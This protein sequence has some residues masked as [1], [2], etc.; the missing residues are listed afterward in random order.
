MGVFYLFNVTYGCT[1][2]TYGP[3]YECIESR[4][5]QSCTRFVATVRPP[6]RRGR[7]DGSRLFSVAASGISVPPAGT[8]IETRCSVSRCED[9]FY[10][11][12]FRKTGRTSPFL[13]RSERLV[14]KRHCE[15]S[16]GGFAG[17]REKAWVNDHEVGATRS[18]WNIGLIAC[19]R[20]SWN[21]FMT[22]WYRTNDGSLEHGNPMRFGR[23]I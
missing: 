22:F 23:R 4:T 12:T 1:V 10:R 15:S 17:A 6:A 13:R 5:A 7:T 14:V 18:S 19:Y 20:Q 8:T 21:K 2:M 3:C 9:P 11:K 16:A